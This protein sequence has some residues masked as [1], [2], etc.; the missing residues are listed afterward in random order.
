MATEIHVRVL[1]RVVKEQQA[2]ARQALED[3]NAPEV[4]FPSSKLV[5]IPSRDGRNNDGNVDGEVGNH[6]TDMAPFIRKKLGQGK[7]SHLFRRQEL[8]VITGLRLR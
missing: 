7:R 5:A 2:Q 1:G 4:P 6:N 3:G 8:S